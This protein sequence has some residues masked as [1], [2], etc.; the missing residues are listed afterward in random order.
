MNFTV[1]PGCCAAENPEPPPN[2]EVVPPNGLAVV[3]VVPNSPP[4]LVL[5]P[6]PG[7]HDVR[8]TSSGRSDVSFHKQIKVTTGLSNLEK[9]T[10]FTVF[11]ER[12]IFKHEKVG[13]C[14]VMSFF[15]T[16]SWFLISTLVCGY[17]DEPH[18]LLEL[19]RNV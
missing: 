4:L 17:C 12:R 7:G 14:G 1:V 10:Y 9:Q 13:L 2:R 8:E 15:L 19:R 18:F 3:L 5:V 16:L 6:K 11:V